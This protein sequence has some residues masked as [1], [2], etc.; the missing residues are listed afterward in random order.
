[1]KKFSAE[2]IGTFVLVFIGCTAA[3]VSAKSPADGLSGIGLLGIALAFG[4]S[5]VAMAYAIGL[6]R[7][8]TST[9]Q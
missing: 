2:L 9:R 4:G 1:M 5:V 8:A 7:V 6:F 3:V